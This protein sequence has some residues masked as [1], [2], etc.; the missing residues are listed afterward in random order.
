MH[1]HG[2]GP[3][4]VL[5]K[6]YGQWQRGRYRRVKTSIRGLR[7]KLSIRPSRHQLRLGF[8]PPGMAR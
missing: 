4:D 3:K 2:K 7:S 8:D 5:V 1:H 6:G